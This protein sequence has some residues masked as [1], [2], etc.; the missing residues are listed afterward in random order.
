M[1]FKQYDVVRIVAFNKPV[2]VVRDAINGR[3]PHVGDV[4]TIVEL[5]DNPP[6]YELECVEK[7]GSTAW[8]RS[9]APDKIE[10]EPV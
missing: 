8:L 1:E 6:G 3:E 7:G 4:A 10:L 2:M 9:F 5:Y